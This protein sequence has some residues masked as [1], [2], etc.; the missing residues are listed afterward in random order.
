MRAR[1]IL[2][3]L[4]GTVLAPVFASA[5]QQQTSR[6]TTITILQLNDVYQ[7]SP[8]DKGKR[9]GLTRVG[10]LQKKIRE[11]S[12]NTLFSSPAISSRR[13]LPRACSRKADGCG[14]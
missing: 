5:Q 11:Q 7:F 2:Y 14:A 6:T 13:P 12:P 1:L 10:T 4:C 8:V 9:G 3:V